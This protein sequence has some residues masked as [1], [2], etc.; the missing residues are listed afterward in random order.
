MVSCPVC[1]TIAGGYYRML[2]S[3]YQIIKCSGCGLE[4]TYP[5]PNEYTINYSYQ[6]YHDI[7]ADSKIVK[8]N[9]DAHLR[10]LEEYGWNMES[11]MLDFGAGNGEF[12][13]AG[14]INCYGIEIKDSSNPRIKKRLKD[15]PNLSWEFITLWGVLEHLPNPNEIFNKLVLKLNDGGI[16]ALTTVDAE[17]MIPYYYKPPEHLTYWTYDAFKVLAKENGLNI[18]YYK[19]YF[20]YQL[21]NIYKQRLLS[22]TPIEYQSCFSDSLPELV[23]VPTNEICVMLM[24]RKDV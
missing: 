23:Y 8:I 10:F 7:R 17:G 19:T 21:G 22:R 14:G 9:S 3:H 16:I 5:I 11:R 2:D 4:Y 15:L 1:Q 13:E 6:N 20:M 18:I 24:K 12:V